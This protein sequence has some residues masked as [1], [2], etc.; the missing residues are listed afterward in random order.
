MNREKTADTL[1]G[2]SSGTGNAQLVLFEYGGING[3]DK[4]YEMWLV[5]DRSL[6]L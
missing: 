3:F 4:H 1:C 5:G 2:N 6:F